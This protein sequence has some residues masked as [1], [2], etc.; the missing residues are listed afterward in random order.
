MITLIIDGQTIKSRDD[1]T[2]LFA[3]REAGITTI[4]TLCHN[5]TLEPYGSC[6]L[7][8]VEIIQNGKTTI[9]CSCTYPAIEDIEVKT[10]SPRVIENRRFVIELLLARSPNVKKVQELALDYG[11]NNI[12]E[13][14]NRNNEYCILCG[15]CIRACNEVVQAHA[16]DFSGKGLNRIVDTPFHVSPSECI[17]CGSCAFVCPTGIIKLKDHTTT[18]VQEPEGVIEKGPTREITNWQVEDELQICN[19]CGN[20]F[21]SLSLL[22]KLSEKYSYN[23]NFFN[24]CPSCRTYPSI[25]TDLCTACNSCIVVCPVGAAHFI[26]DGEDQKSHICTQHCCGCHSCIEVCGWGAIK[27]DDK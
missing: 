6:R 19:S 4:P 11:V 25:D 17:A 24:L 21:I 2:V 1:T 3:A 8:L 10:N 22:K 20:P 23:M 27:I 7:C 9:E 5:D 16:I 18:R 13:Q 12:P 14:W 26:E 15:M